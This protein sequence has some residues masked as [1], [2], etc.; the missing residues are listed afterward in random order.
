VTKIQS[1]QLLYILHLQTVTPVT[2]L[3]SA[4]TKTAGWRPPFSHSGTH[5]SPAGKESRTAGLASAVGLRALLLLLARLLFFLHALL[6]LG[7][8]L[9]ELLGLLLVALFDLLPSCVIGILLGQALVVLLLFLLELLMF[10]LL[11]VVELVLLLLVFLVLPGIARVRR[12]RPIVRRNLLGVRER[13]TVGVVH[14]I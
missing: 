5:L 7:V 1:P 3:E 14:R 10:L 2:P 6:L 11:F 8:A 9:L 13:G 4:F 12:S